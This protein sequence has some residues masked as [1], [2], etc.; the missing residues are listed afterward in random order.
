MQYLILLLLISSIKLTA[1]S[2]Y[3]QVD[4]YAKKLHIKTKNTLK[5]AHQLTNQFE[6]TKVNMNIKNRKLKKNK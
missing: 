5:I 6:N 3:N 4:K 2:D 1:Q